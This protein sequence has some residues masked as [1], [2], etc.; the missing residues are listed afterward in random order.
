MCKS[1]LGI[2]LVYIFSVFYPY[3]ILHGRR[4]ANFKYI[5]LVGYGR[6]FE[7]NNV[8]LDDSRRAQSYTYNAEMPQFGKVFKT[9]ENTKTITG[10]SA[11]GL[12]G[13]GVCDKFFKNQCQEALH[14]GLQISIDLSS[15]LAPPNHTNQ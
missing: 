12:L 1:P 8:Q 4:R 11:F 14:L 9:L 3:T 2:P 7:N 15:I 6:G 13:N 10:P 5:F